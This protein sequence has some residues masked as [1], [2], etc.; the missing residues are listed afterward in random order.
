MK[1]NHLAIALGAIL[2]LATFAG[3]TIYDYSQ[4]DYRAFRM[5]GTLQSECI[6]GSGQAMSEIPERCREP[7][8]IYLANRE[9]MYAPAALFGFACTVALWLIIGIAAW[10]RRKSR[11]GD[12]SN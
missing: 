6:A 3:G 5:A 8:R 1:R 4:R 9:S 12:G 2:T 7:I 10:A 11:S